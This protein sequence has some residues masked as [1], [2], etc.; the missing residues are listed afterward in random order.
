[1]RFRVALLIVLIILM[2]VSPYSVG[3]REINYGFEGG[4]FK[5]DNGVIT[6]LVPGDP[7][8]TFPFYIFWLNEEPNKKYVAFYLGLTE[9]WKEIGH[10]FR[11]HEMFDDS[12]DMALQVISKMGGDIGEKAKLA[13]F[14]DQVDSIVTLA[15]SG[16]YDELKSAI[17]EAMDYAKDIGIENEVFDEL[18]VMLSDLRNA[19]T[20]Y[21]ELNENYQELFENASETLQYIY[22]ID[23]WSLLDMYYNSIT[24]KYSEINATIQE[25][26]SN[27]TTPDEALSK[28]EEFSVMMNFTSMNG[29]LD[30]TSSYIIDLINVIYD[31]IQSIN[32]TEIPSLMTEL[33]FQM[34]IFMQAYYMWE[35]DMANTFS[36]LKS[37]IEL[38]RSGLMRAYELMDKLNNTYTSMLAEI[39]FEDQ[40]YNSTFTSIKSKMVETINSLSTLAEIEEAITS[41]LTEVSNLANSIR[42]KAD[43]LRARENLDEFGS[44]I[45]DVRMRIS[46]MHAFMLP[47]VACRWKLEV[48]TEIF[49]QNNEKVGVQFAFILEEV[50]PGWN[51][52]KGDIIIRNRIYTIPVNEIYGNMSSTVSRFEIKN[53]IVIRHWDWN[54][55]ILRGISDLNITVEPSLVLIA[56]FRLD[57][58]DPSYISEMIY[59]NNEQPMENMEVEVGDNKFEIEMEHEDDIVGNILMLRSPE[60]SYDGFF[61]F[62][63]YATIVCQ[64]ET[65]IVP[66]DGV[67]YTFGGIMRVFIVYPYFGDCELEHDPS[68]GTMAGIGEKPQLTI[69]LAYLNWG[70]SYQPIE[71]PGNVTQPLPP[72][73]YTQ[74]PEHL[75]VQEIPTGGG[76]IDRNLIMAIGIIATVAVATIIAYIYAKRQ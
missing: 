9:V 40:G 21:L 29:H 49:S 13:D 54:I 22:T 66:V 51:L 55:D 2:A 62:N 52:G 31:N 58:K 44:L 67:F 20:T 43:E 45:N 3:A 30:Q 7:S 50:P 61:K 74:P 4:W 72:E 8:K 6:V 11:H 38:F 48:T 47:F 28:L 41:L 24:N 16:Y 15:D 42:E 10:P 71:M 17:D 35:N 27:K 53:D 39:S 1:L 46:N 63:P 5:I 60:Y 36:I 59:S 12:R 34:N 32:Y 57:R 76:G 69:D 25:L 75:P 19:S 70:T 64:N 37:D 18:V 68:V 23:V 14:L 26:L 65:R 33:E 56:G 73:N